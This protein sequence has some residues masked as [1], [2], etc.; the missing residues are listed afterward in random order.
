MSEVYNKYYI[1]VLC[2][3]QPELI[4]FLIRNS[5]DY[6]HL[7]H[8]MYRADSTTMYS[9]SMTDQIEL[10]LRLSVDLK[11]CMNFSNLARNTTSKLP[12]DVAA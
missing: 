5:I 12:A 1:R 6:T 10:S 8:D 2:D 4:D 7:E 9:V 11:G 3:D